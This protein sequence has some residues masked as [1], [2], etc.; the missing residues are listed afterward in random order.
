MGS[1]SCKPVTTAES[2]RRPSGT[3]DARGHHALRLEQAGIPT[4]ARSGSREQGAGGRWGSGL[5]LLSWC[6]IR[7]SWP[8]ERPGPLSGEEG[9]SGWMGEA[10]EPR[11]V[12]RGRAG[13]GRGTWCPHRVDVSGFKCFRSQGPGALRCRRNQKWV[14][15]R[16]HLPIAGE[17]HLSKTNARCERGS[18]ACDEL[19]S[20][21]KSP[22]S[23]S[24]VLSAD[25][26]LRLPTYLTLPSFCL[27]SDLVACTA[28]DLRLPT[29][30]SC[31]PKM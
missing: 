1:S 3:P 23:H 8:A 27:P 11:H 25:D 7:A 5:I 17:G 6:L 24:P 15:G 16:L 30:F 13:Y 20:A 26:R 28:A 22:H 19:S 4:T 9:S 10:L 14:R 29:W 21:G 2:V 31:A 18:G 12:P